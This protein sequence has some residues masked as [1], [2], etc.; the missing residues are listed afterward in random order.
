M[1]SKEAKPIL[2][3]DLHRPIKF[4]DCILHSWQDTNFLCTWPSFLMWRSARLLT[5]LTAS[6]T[7][8]ML[9]CRLKV[10]S[11]VTRATEAAPRRAPDFDAV[12]VAKPWNYN[13]RW[14]TWSHKAFLKQWVHFL[15][16]H[17]HREITCFTFIFNPFSQWHLASLEE[18]DDSIISSQFEFA[19]R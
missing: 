18:P 19:G 11:V 13:V 4:P 17:N 1:L 15:E 9:S 8:V 3:L 12:V 7:V 2:E 16:C 14:C 10:S 5:F 6:C